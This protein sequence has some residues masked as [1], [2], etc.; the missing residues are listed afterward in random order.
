MAAPAAF[1]LMASPF[2]PTFF[3][4]WVGSF[5]WFVGMSQQFHAWSHMRRSELPEAVLWLQDNGLL[6][7]CKAHG[8][9][10]KAPFDGN[11]CIVSGM[12]N[13]LLD[14]GGADT[15]FF[16]RL[17]RLVHKA[18]GHEPRCWYSPE[19]I[20]WEEGSYYKPDASVLAE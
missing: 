1:F 12:W 15:G 19:E 5:M 13:D 7:S 4:C 14:Q 18:T 6:I 8:A 20:G 2:T 10:H 16:R 11:Y 17:E 3:G 9:H